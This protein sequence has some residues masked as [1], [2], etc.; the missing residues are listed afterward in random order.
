MYKV[1]LEAILGFWK[2]GEKLYF[3]PCIPK[4]WPGFSVRYRYLQSDYQIEVKNPQGTYRGVK[5]I[6]VNGRALKN[7]FLP[8]AGDGKDYQVEVI[9]G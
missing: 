2:E 7:N 3:K 9:L 8:L 6:T 1:G 5:S 4:D